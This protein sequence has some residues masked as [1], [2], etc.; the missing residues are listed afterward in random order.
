MP[1]QT[2]L[3]RDWKMINEWASANMTVTCF[4]E[5]HDRLLLWWGRQIIQIADY[6]D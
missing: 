3:D 1:L 4:T 5:E 6:N 2:D